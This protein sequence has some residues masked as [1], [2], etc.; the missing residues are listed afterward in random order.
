MRTIDLK[1]KESQLGGGQDR[2]DTQHKKGKLTA[3]ERVDLLLDAGTSLFRS[4]LA[5]SGHF[6]LHQRRHWRV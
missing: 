5:C 2:I 1:R 4:V 3:R 6:R